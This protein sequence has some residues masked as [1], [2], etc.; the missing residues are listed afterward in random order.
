MI[1]EYIR[2]VRDGRRVKIGMLVAGRRTNGHVYV[3][4]SKCNMGKD[5]FDRKVAHNIAMKRFNDLHSKV[6]PPE[7]IRKDVLRFMSRCVRFYQVGDIRI[8]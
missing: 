3:G 8:A 5:E 6:G 2:R 7:S 1:S 4:W